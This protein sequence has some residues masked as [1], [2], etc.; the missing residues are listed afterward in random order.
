MIIETATRPTSERQKR[1]FPPHANYLYD[2]RSDSD[3][4]TSDD[5]ERELP[6]DKKERRTLLRR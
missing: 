1:P 4:R 2:F 3:D 6:I 5:V